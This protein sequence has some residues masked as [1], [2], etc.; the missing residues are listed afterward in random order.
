LTNLGAIGTIP[1]HMNAFTLDP[2]DQ[3]IAEFLQF[4]GRIA[5][6]E[7]ACRVGATETTI[8]IVPGIRDGAEKPTPAIPTFSDRWCQPDE[9]RQRACDAITAGDGQVSHGG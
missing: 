6:A 8:G 5:N 1:T 2:L 4:D 7:I 3:R 9:W